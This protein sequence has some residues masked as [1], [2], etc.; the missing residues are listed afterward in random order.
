MDDCLKG[1]L[2]LL[3]IAIVLIVIGSVV[4]VW[5]IPHYIEKEEGKPECEESKED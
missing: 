3:V 2:V 4:N 5:V 1:I